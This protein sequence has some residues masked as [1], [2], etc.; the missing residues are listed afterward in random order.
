MVTLTNKTNRHIEIEDVELISTIINSGAVSKPLDESKF[1]ARTN[2]LIKS[3][4][5]FKKE[6]P[7]EPKKVVAE[8]EDKKTSKKSK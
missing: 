7:V 2:R 4:Q 1:T 3:G 6:L 8:T 5:L